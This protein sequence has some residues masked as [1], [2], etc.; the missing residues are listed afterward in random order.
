MPSSCASKC[1]CGR[2]RS[3][4]QGWRPPRARWTAAEDGAGTRLAHDDDY[5]MT[6]DDAPTLEPAS[7]HTR[8]R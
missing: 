2:L 5:V 8:G 6:T 1:A 7:R 4:P 3:S